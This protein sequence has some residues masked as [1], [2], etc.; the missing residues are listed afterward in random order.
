MLSLF[1]S[2]DN[3]N[4][5]PFEG[6]VY[7]LGAI[8]GVSEA[9][10]YAHYLLESIAWEY[11]KVHI[12]GKEVVTKRKVAWFGDRPYAY[13]YSGTTRYAQLWDEPIR[14]LKKQVENKA[15]EVFNACLLNLYH[16][17]SEGMSWHCDDEKEIIPNSTIAS[18]SFGATRK[19]SFKHKETKQTQ[20]VY[21]EPGSLLLM[22]GAVQSYWLHSLPK[23]KKV[24][25]PRI[26]LTFRKICT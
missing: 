6:E 7:Y 23:T 18:L 5:L 26:N 3:G 13:T 19:F 8:F 11:D 16:N 25:R 14:E 2:Q 10:M 22:K 1:D 21:L 9:K 24:D 12:F 4:L 15:Q 20:H 17:G